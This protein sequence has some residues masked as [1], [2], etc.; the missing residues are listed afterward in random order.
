MMAFEELMRE[1]DK[2]RRP[3]AD[4][5]RELVIY[6]ETSVAL[7]SVP[8]RTIPSRSSADEDVVRASRV[9]TAT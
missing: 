6:P 1:L 7:K 4:Q 8:P 3:I 5:R 9:R 2:A